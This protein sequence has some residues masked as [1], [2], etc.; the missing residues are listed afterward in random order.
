MA[1]PKYLNEFV[2]AFGDT[3]GHKD[4]KFTEAAVRA[5]LS[6]ETQC[7]FDPDA[8]IAAYAYGLYCIARSKS[9]IVNSNDAVMNLILWDAEAYGSMRVA[10]DAGSTREVPFY[11]DPAL[12][13]KGATAASV[14]SA[15]RAGANKMD[16]NAKLSFILLTEDGAFVDSFND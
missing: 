4:G 2:K 10:R 16:G 3:I 5:H 12:G 11:G 13:F 9:V 8:Q 1:E 6:G 14:L 7:A 15:A